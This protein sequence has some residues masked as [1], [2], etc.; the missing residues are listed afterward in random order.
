[1]GRRKLETCQDMGK[2]MEENGAGGGVDGRRRWGQANTRQGTGGI[3]RQCSLQKAGNI[4]AESPM[5]R[6][7]LHF[8]KARKNLKCFCT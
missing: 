6:T 8:Q 4:L 5:Y 7:Y 1:M 3:G 2:E